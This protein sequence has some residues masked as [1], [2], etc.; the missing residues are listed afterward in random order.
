MTYFTTSRR[1]FLTA[2]GGAFSALA[3]MTGRANAQDAEELG[4]NADML[5][6]AEQVLGVQYSEVEREQLLSAVADQLDAVLALR[7]MDK[8][9]ALAP[10]L[11]FDPR[12]PGV[13]Y[14]STDEGVTGLSGAAPARP[15]GEDDIAFAPAHVQAA[16][17]RDGALT[18][19]ELTD[20]YLRRLERLGPV[21]QCIVALSP[22]RARREA[23]AADAARARGEAVD[24]LHGLPYLIKDLFDAE[25]LPTTWGA[26]TR[27]DVEPAQRD[28]AV[29]ARLKAA[30]CVL[31]G[32]ATCGALAYGDI[33]FG[34]VTRNPWSLEEGSSGSSAGS[35]AAVAAGL[36]SFAIG[37]E[38]MGSIVSPAHRC[39]VTGLRPSF[40][41]ISRAGGMALCWSLDKVGVLARASED[42]ALV[43]AAIN[44]GDIDDPSCRETGF[45]CDLNT[46][47]AGLRVGYDPRWDETA[48]ALDIAAREAL[49][50]AGVELVERDMPAPPADELALAL[51]VEASAAFEELTLS[52]QDDRLTWQDDAAWPNTFRAAR[53]I[54]AI[55][56]VQTTRIRRRVMGE[57]HAAFDGLDAIAGPNF[58]GGMLNMTNFTGQPQ[59]AVRAGFIETPPRTLF[60]APQNPDAAPV[61]VPYATSLWAPLYREDVL[62]ALGRALEARLGVAD[63]RPV[64]DVQ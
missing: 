15:S 20:T 24:P 38:T 62:I 28:S 53:F 1:G 39:G 26:S 34:G 21:L 13:S 32:K 50:D 54:S 52:N 61:R 10:A 42:A 22:E 58:A 37:T 7:G 19:R 27:S 16:W 31:L 55:D 11:V 18:S 35:A 45:S 46:D 12:I 8:P 23:D 63:A 59:L 48:D 29:A 64:L 56:Y 41:R 49:A 3:A 33:W 36:S 17:L 9:N 43:L 4:L 30:G 6:S 44:G 14:P 51:L 2:A 25:G 5:A 60:G 47:V 40:G 57:M